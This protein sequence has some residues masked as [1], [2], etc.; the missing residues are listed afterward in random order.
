MKDKAELLD[1]TD[2][3]VQ[4]IPRYAIKGLGEDRW[5]TRKTALNDEVLISHLNG[6][7]AVAGLGKW[8]PGHALL[9][10]D[11][12]EI[13]YVKELRESLGMDEYNSM[14][15]TSESKD[16]YHLLF[17]P[18][19]NRQPPTLK[20]LNDIIQPFAVERGIEA[21]PRAQKPVRLP[22]GKVQ[23]ILDEGKEHLT[24]WEE[25]LYWFQK[26]D[27][28]D[29]GTVP[30]SQRLLALEYPDS[31]GR[32]PV[33]REGAEYFKHGLQMQGER[34]RATFAV[35]Y[36]LWRMNTPMSVA[37]ETTWTWLKTMNNGVSE[38]W[39]CGQYN[40]CKQH[41]QDCAIRIW[42]YEFTH[43]YPDECHNNHAGWIAKEDIKRIFHTV[44]GSVVKARFLYHLLKHMNPRQ[45]QRA[46]PIHTDLLLKWSSSR[47][48]L[49]R[50]KEFTEMG[51]LQRGGWYIVGEQSKTVAL[52]WKYSPPTDAVLIDGRSP[53][54]LESTVTACFEPEEYRGLLRDTGINRHSQISLTKEAF[55]GY[56]T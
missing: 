26:L 42:G 5:H 22:F 54:H 23:S 41:I 52:D 27:E 36:F 50:I 19:Y 2:S 37:K 48:Y 15:C 53:D 9:D 35:M 40:V 47:A 17:R 32:L 29:L 10:I 18:V 20:L 4:R 21:Y 28:Y 1:Y 3:F 8:Y 31:R 24:A 12:R 34:D 46:V 13:G 45:N 14:L 44:G 30:Y 11:S 38:T 33:Y 16:S 55:E 7:L 6:E 49:N 51:I 56:S 43:D 39:N 25:K